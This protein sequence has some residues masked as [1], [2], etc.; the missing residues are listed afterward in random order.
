MHIRL[1]SIDG[2]SNEH[3]GICHLTFTA[4]LLGGLNELR[5][6]KVQRAIYP[7]GTCGVEVS[8]H[9]LETFSRC[10]VNST[11]QADFHAL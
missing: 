2:R 7:N 8:S 9:S 4:K 6:W 5:F 10:S 1:S 11:G 3:F